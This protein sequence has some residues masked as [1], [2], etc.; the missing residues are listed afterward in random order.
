MLYLE[1]IGLSTRG[2]VFKDKMGRTLSLGSALR[3]ILNRGFNYILDMELFIVRAIGWVPIYL[4]R[5]LIYQM[6]GVKIGKKTHIHM[7]TQF[8][9][10]AG[11]KI[12]RGA[13]IGQNAFLDGRA[14]LLIGDNVDIASDVMIY[15]SEH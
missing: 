3:K 8:F 6:S 5:K 4:I 12:G 13:I 2:L 15:N 1:H 14:K 11:V 7:G 10:P 9:Y